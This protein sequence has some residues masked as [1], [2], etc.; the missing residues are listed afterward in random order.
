MRCLDRT[1]VKAAPANLCLLRV[2][3]A[4]ADQEVW[5]SLCAELPVDRRGE[6]DL[7]PGNGQDHRQELLKLARPAPLGERRSS[8]AR[9]IRQVGVRQAV[10]YGEQALIE[11]AVRTSER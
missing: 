8:R 2:G 4:D 3:N 7:Q 10:S 1:A 6:H 5:R 11:G 9:E